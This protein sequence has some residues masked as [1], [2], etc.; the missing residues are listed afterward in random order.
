MAAGS[1]LKQS[2]GVNLRRA[3]VNAGHLARDGDCKKFGLEI[4]PPPS[5]TDSMQK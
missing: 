3:L 2:I 4:L 1:I 5:V